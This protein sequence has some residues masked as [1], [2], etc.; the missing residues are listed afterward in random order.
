MLL[1]IPQVLQPDKPTPVRQLILAANRADGRSTAGG[2]NGAV[3]YN[4]QWPEN[5]PAALQ[6]R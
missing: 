5:M 3:K 1:R 2:R 6:A 4:R